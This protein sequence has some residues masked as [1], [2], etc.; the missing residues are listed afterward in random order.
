MFPILQI[1]GLAVQV[2]GLILLLGLWVGLS[3]AERRS[4][5]YGIPAETLYNL[6]FACLVAGVTGARLTYAG[7]HLDVFI[8]SPLGLFSLRPELL[9]PLGGLAAALLVAGI[10]IQRRSLRPGAVLDALTPLFAILLIA[11]PAANY[12]SGDAYGSLAA[13]PWAVEL[14]GA[15][16]HPVQIYELLA[17][18]GI[19]F[20]LGARP[21]SKEFEGQ[22]AG[23]VFLNFLVL[24]AAARLFLEAFRGESPVIGPGLRIIQLIAWAVMAAGLVGLWLPDRTIRRG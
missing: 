16:R 8:R 7:M 15:E 3:A 2:P 20:Y 22:P 10:I 13:L 5:L 19:F 4:R 14:W 24:S 23:G 17:A 18:L 11:V 12:A 9:D 6:V 1:G 21:R